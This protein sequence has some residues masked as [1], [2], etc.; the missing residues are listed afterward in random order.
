VTAYPTI[1]AL[2]PVELHDGIHFKRED[3]YRYP[4]GANGSK[5]RACEV[6]VQSAKAAGYSRIV[7]AAACV[8]PQ[9]ALVA[10]T[11][12]RFGMETTH[13]L[14]GTKPSTAMQHPSVRVA[15]ET[16]VATFVF[17]PVGYNPYLVSQARK[18]AAEHE[19]HYWLHYGI[20][21][22]EDATDA[23][24]AAFHAPGQQQVANLPEGIKTLILPFGSGNS[25]TGVLAGLIDHAPL[26]LERVVLPII[27]PDHRQWSTDRLHRMGLP[28]PF[29]DFGDELGALTFELQPETLHKVWASYGDKMPE[30]R[31]GIRF[32]PT[33]EG[34]IVRWLNTTKPDYWTAQDGTT[35]MW[36]VGGPV[37]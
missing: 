31:D 21:T 37:R 16:G 34:K 24:V 11:A 22:P 6:L 1:G 28:S 4:S 23:E 5:L 35:A 7:T 15:A 18:F 20:T 27:G 17:L 8:S 36:I 3:L 2:S 14:G 30:T 25:G 33:Y 29:V 12:A 19:D 13:L 26:T 9:H 10:S 32:H